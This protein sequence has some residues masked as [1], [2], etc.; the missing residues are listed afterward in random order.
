MKIARVLYPVKTLGPGN[1]LGIWTWGCKRACPGC[2]NPELWEAPDNCD[3]PL[4]VLK[5]QVDKL[6][7]VG[8]E[9][10]G[11]DRFDGAGETAGAG[12]DDGVPRIDGVTISGGEPFNQP[13]ELER[14]VDYL[15]EFTDD[16][17]IF[18]GYR[19]EELA[20]Y[21]SGIISKLAVLVD[22]EY[23]EEKNEGHPLR[24]SSNQTM[25][26]VNQDKRQLY[27][28][29]IQ[30]NM[31]KNRT[32]LFPVAGGQVAV[33]IHG[34][35]FHDRHSELAGSRGL[36]KRNKTGSFGIVD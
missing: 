2:A 19:R 29:Y 30:E 34:R 35:D 20:E 27:E 9:I 22:G 4:E 36:A 6:R 14:L 33:G 10:D 21:E 8:S 25:H 12:G 28:N 5:E 7:G 1:R 31:G 32:Q 18:T 13:K 15:R 26:Y 3:V 17:L 24:G 23:L 16:I 11:A